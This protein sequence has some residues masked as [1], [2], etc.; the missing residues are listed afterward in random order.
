M[1]LAPGVVT[2]GRGDWRRHVARVLPDDMRGLRALDV[3]TFAGFWAF[4]MERRGADVVAIDV[5]DLDAVDLPPPQRARLERDAAAGGLELG[6]GF[7]WRRRCSARRRGACRA[8]ST[9]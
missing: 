4:E 2:P 7:R 3:G 8:A 6:H 9:T 5:D 1:E